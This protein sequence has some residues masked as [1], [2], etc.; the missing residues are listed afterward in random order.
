MAEILVW[1]DQNNPSVFDFFL[2]KN[3]FVL[4]LELLNMKG[5]PY[6]KMQ[7]LQ[8]LNIIF[9]NIRNESSLYYFMSNNYINNVITHKYDF[10]NEEILA[11]Y[12]S[13]MKTLS[14]R[15]SPSTISFFY[16]EHQEDFP[17]YSEA[18]K[19]FNHKESMVRIA[20][21]TIVLNIFKVERV[22]A[23]VCRALTTTSQPHIPCVYHYNTNYPAVN[24]TLN[25]K[26]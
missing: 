22:R 18:I 12:I 25:P 17:L 7:L 19:F 24:L 8:C 4:F 11:Y 23:Q 1:G 6:V 13:F 20:V 3:L 15:L 2:D 9:E 14:F 10:S 5:V 21:R 16:N 26:P